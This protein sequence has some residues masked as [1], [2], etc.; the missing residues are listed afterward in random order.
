M[1]HNYKNELHNFAARILT[2]TIDAQNYIT[3]AMEIL[4]EIPHLNKEAWES[5]VESEK[6]LTDIGEVAEKVY[7]GTENEKD[8]G[9]VLLQP[10]TEDG[11]F[12]TEQPNG[13]FKMVKHVHR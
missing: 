9:F 12:F 1:D 7:Q 3:G 11:I 13:K 8:D 10:N 4:R 5:L 2:A 6:I